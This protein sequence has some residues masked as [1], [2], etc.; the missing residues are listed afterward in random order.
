[1]FSENMSL[2]EPSASKHMKKLPTGSFNYYLREQPQKQI[3]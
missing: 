2:F 3:G 1:M